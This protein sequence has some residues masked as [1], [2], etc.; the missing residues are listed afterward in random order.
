[1]SEIRTPRRVFG[2]KREK[3]TRGWEK[4]YNEEL[5][6]VYLSPKSVG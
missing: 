2:P 4:L 3:E 5:R 1:V 6:K